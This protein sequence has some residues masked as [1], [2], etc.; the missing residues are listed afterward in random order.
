MKTI[1]FIMM[2]FVLF[3][4][5][6]VQAAPK[7][8]SAFDRV[9]RTGALRCAYATWPPYLD[10]DPN[11][12]ALS[13]LSYDYMEEIG[14][15]LDLKIEWTEEVGWGNYIEGLNNNRYDAM[16][17]S[18]WAVGERL[19]YST[20]TIP[21]LYSALYAYVREGDTRFD[22]N[23]G[24]I[25][26]SGLKIAVIEGDTTFNVA[27]LNFPQAQH[28]A[29][30]QNSDAAQLLMEV[31]TG[32][33]DLTI[34]DD[35]IANE[36]IRANPG[37]IRKVAAVPAVQIFPEVYV[38]KKGERDLKDMIDGAILLITNTDFAQGLV[39]RYGV[40]QFVPA[41]TYQAAQ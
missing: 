23:L 41:K 9:I 28:D 36:F 10:K 35:N 25:N 13:G 19:K 16:C 18:D 22:G 29:I 8:E 32:K 20:V 12:G 15:I 38:L 31:T 7:D 27:R 1:K 4:V 24:A 33:A 30:S 40:Q 5:T 14:R 34:V 2:F 6:A 3:S 26:S 21:T 37:S 11:T 17:S 39:A